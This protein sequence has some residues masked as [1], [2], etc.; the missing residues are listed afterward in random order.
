MDVVS[1]GDVAAEVVDAVL[2]DE[3]DA[4]GFPAFCGP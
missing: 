4:A 3:G 2:V 1:T